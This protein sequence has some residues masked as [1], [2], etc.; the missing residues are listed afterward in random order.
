MS[1][2][3]RIVDARSR[4]RLSANASPTA[5]HCPKPTTR[6]DTSS[7]SSLGRRCRTSSRL[8]LCATDGS[9]VQCRWSKS[10]GI[11][12]ELNDI[13]ISKLPQRP[14]AD[15]NQKQ[16]PPVPVTVATETPVKVEATQ[17][18]TADGAPPKVEAVVPKGPTSTM[19]GVVLDPHKQP[20]ADAHVRVYESFTFREDFLA[21]TATDS[22][23]KFSIQGIPLEREGRWYCKLIV[24]SPTFATRVTTPATTGTSAEGLADLEIV[25]SVPSSLRGRVVGPDFKPVSGA[26]IFA[27]PFKVP[28]PGAHSTKTDVNGYFEIRDIE[29][30]DSGE[31]AAAGLALAGD[32][33]TEVIAYGVSHVLRVRH[34]DFGNGTAEY[35]QVPLTLLVRLQEP[36]EVTGRILDSRTS[37]PLE[38]IPVT[39][40][41]ML[42]TTDADGRYRLRVQPRD[43]SIQIEP[44]RIGWSENSISIKAIPGRAGGGQRHLDPTASNDELN[45]QGHR[46]GRRWV[47][48]PARSPPAVSGSPR[49]CRRGST[50]E[51]WTMER[52]YDEVM[53]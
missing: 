2:T 33:K 24:S 44:M 4:R 21:E 34:P 22:S 36:M 53:A 29:P 48:T 41:S 32:R 47:D 43:E 31:V 42:S 30:W 40:G 19:S 20:L 25:L 45:Q 51:L 26:D 12:V 14:D 18:V 15:H 5:T 16:P 11:N 49:R 38:D 6:D 10:P 46:S 17:A 1:V 50:R 39:C 3:G 27:P 52:L 23:G 8:P 9:D 37:T 35:R 28:V 7:S 13:A